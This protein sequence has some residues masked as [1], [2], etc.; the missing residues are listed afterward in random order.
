MARILDLEEFSDDRGAL[1]V[2]ENQLPFEIRRVYWIYEASGVRGGHAHKVT[3]QGLVSVSGRCQVDVKT[4]KE[5]EIFILDR[6]NQ[7]LLLNPEDWH[8]MSH[9]TKDSVLAVFASHPY[10]KDDY[11]M[12]MPN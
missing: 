5:T 6:P 11:I 4:K 2:I 12:E 3:R 8:T 10:N 1:C 9:F 7:V